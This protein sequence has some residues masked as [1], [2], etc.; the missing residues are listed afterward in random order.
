MFR[1]FGICPHFFIGLIGLLI[2]S[3]SQADYLLGPN[4]VV[5]I[6]VYGNEDL[7]TETRVSDSGKIT[8]P[9]LGEIELGGLSVGEAEA[10]VETLLSE[11]GYVRNPQVNITVQEYRSHE[12]A[13]LGFVNKPGRFA[14]DT[15]STVTQLIALA[16]GVNPQG[17]DRTIVTRTRN[18]QTYREELNLKELLEEGKASEDIFAEDGDVIFVPRAPVF[19][20]HGEVQRPGAYRLERNMSVAQAISLG[21]GVTPRGSLRSITIKRR[22][23]EDHLTTLDAELD[24]LIEKDDVIYVDERWF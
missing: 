21:G 13:V 2:L 24:E 4:D 9:L 23:S 7:A 6:A 3:T 10:R 18:G 15:A 8:F 14:L 19:Y 12:V 16:G 20:I 22:S 1:P 11:R 17:D 5:R